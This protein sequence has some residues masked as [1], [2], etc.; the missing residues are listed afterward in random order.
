MVV[1][2]V[3]SVTPD[4]PELLEWDR[5]EFSEPAKVPDGLTRKNLDIGVTLYTPF[6]GANDFKLVVKE[7]GPEQRT[8]VEII[9]K[10]TELSPDQA[11]ALKKGTQAQDA[12]VVIVEGVSEVFV[13]R[14]KE[15]VL[16]VIDGLDYLG[17]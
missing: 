16:Y 17:R 10:K 1:A 5:P 4:R 3:L 14:Q 12:F 2:G 15:P 8:I 9:G 11:A 13:Q 7:A 6:F